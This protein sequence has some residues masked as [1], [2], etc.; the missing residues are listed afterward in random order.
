MRPKIFLSYIFNTPTPKISV[1]NIFMIVLVFVLTFQIWILNNYNEEKQFLFLRR[2]LLEAKADTL[3]CQQKVVINSSPKMER[4]YWQFLNTSD[5]YFKL[6][7]AY[8]DVRTSDHMIRIISY[9]NRPFPTVKTYCQFWYSDE[10]FPFIVPVQEYKLMWRFA[11]GNNTG[12]FSPF[13]LSCKNPLK[14]YVPN[15]VSITEKYCEMATNNLKLIY[16]NKVSGKK[17]QFAICVKRMLFE[18]DESEKLI[19][20]VEIVN[21]LG[22]DKTFLY[23]VKEE[24]HMMKVARYYEKIGKMKIERLTDATDD[25]DHLQG[26]QNEM[27]SI[28]DCLYKNMYEYEFLLV[29]DLDEIIVPTRSEDMSWADLINRVTAEKPNSPAYTALNVY[30]LMNNVHFEDIQTEVPKDMSFLQHVY[31]AK[32]FSKLGHAV[33]SFVNT[34]QTLVL[35]N[36]LPLLHLNGDYCWNRHYFEK[37]DAKLHHYRKGCETVAKELCDDYKQNTVRD[38]T[39]WKW[40]DKI[41]KNFLATKKELQNFNDY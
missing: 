3:Q 40:K 2:K 18:S 14:D 19:E 31:R 6:L 11:W 10:T 34:S 38:T 27:A 26:M 23:V 30:F 4:I 20:W 17:K 12:G 32:N 24:P 35:H 28:N 5:G 41:I 29:I 21:I 25:L 8:Y 33:K 37:S 7:N 22:A 39:L 1:L 13:L 15:S 36:H 16:N 9:I